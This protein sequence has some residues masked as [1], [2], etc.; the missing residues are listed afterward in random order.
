MACR[1][2]SGLDRNDS[3]AAAG[4]GAGAVARGWTLIWSPTHR[5][6]QVGLRQF[7]GGVHVVADGLAGVGDVGAVDRVAG[8]AGELV[9]ADVVEVDPLPGGS[10]QPAHRVQPGT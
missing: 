3:A 10:V 4:A 5:R 1:K 7:A 8:P 2:A 6:R 9:V